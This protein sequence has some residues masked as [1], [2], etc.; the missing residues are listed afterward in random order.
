VAEVKAYELDVD[1]DSEPE[2]KIGRRIIDAEPG[3]TFCTTKLQ[4]G[5]PNEPKEGERLFHSQMWESAPR[6]TSSLIDIAKRTS[7]Q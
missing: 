7:S 5:E 1:S 6:Y 2:P 4:P 3:A